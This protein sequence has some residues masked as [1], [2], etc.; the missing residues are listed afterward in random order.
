MFTAILVLGLFCGAASADPVI[1]A[2]TPAGNSTVENAVG[3]NQTFKVQ[4]NETTSIDW[5]VK[6]IEPQNTSYY[7]ENNTSTLT[8]TIESGE[9]EIEATVRSTGES[10]TLDVN[11]T[12]ASTGGNVTET[13]AEGTVTVIPGKS[14]TFRVNATDDQEMNVEW[15]IDDESKQNDEGVPSFSY[16]FEESTKGEYI[17]KAEI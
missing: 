8:H 3:M 1:I 9:Y 12:A 16:K 10:R 4:T 2:K 11:G 6:G 17:L 5:L 13:P 14:Q 7:T 15:F